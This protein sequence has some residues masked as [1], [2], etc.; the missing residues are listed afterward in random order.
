MAVIE[1]VP[2]C[3][4]EWRDGGQGPACGTPDRFGVQRGSNG[5][6]RR[7]A[8]VEVRRTGPD[9][10][11]WTRPRSGKVVVKRISGKHVSVVGPG[12]DDVLARWRQNCPLPQLRP[13]R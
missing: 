13:S 9:T 3:R 12:G 7:L 10:M 1:A 6:L 4:V 5:V 11:E 8:S 2:E